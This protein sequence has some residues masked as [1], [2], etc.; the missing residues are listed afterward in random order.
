MTP[1]NAPRTSGNIF[2]HTS[3]NLETGTQSSTRVRTAS[4]RRRATRSRRGRRAAR[5]RKRDV[6]TS[7]K[8]SRGARGGTTG[9]RPRRGASPAM[10]QAAAARCTPYVILH[11]ESVWVSSFYFFLCTWKSRHA[12]L[13]GYPAVTVLIGHD[14]LQSSHI[15]LVG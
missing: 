7:T 10:G 14:L 6:P 15:V 11:D 3:S 5:G 2:S 4:R 13:F 1:K 12:S 8:M 9:G